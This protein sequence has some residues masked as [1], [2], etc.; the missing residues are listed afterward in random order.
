MVCTA[1]GVQDTKLH[2]HVLNPYCIP[3]AMLVSGDMEI[4]NREKSRENEMFAD[5]LK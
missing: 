4:F 1:H 2:I 3:S 5:S